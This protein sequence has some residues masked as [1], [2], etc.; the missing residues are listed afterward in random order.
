ML[1]WMSRDRKKSAQKHLAAVWN[2]AG[3]GVAPRAGG[4]Q[5][6][7]AVELLLTRLQGQHG[8]AVETKAQIKSTAN[9]HLGTDGQAVNVSD[10]P[11]PS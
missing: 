8:N 3:G 6:S 4:G 1:T 7:R 2:Y 5:L 11:D 10:H 9:H